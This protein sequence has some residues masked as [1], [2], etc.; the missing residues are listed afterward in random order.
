MTPLSINFTM[1]LKNLILMIYLSIATEIS[2]Y[3]EA[4]CY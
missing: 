1:E 3:F 4:N 2:F